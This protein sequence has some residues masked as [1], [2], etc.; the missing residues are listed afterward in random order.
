MNSQTKQQTKKFLSAI[1]N[2]PDAT[3]RFSTMFDPENLQEK[4]TSKVVN[5]VLKGKQAIKDVINRVEI[6]S[7]VIRGDDIKSETSNTTATSP[8]TSLNS[9]DGGTQTS[10][11][12]MDDNFNWHKRGRTYNNL[13]D[14]VNQIATKDTR[15]L[16]H[17]QE[18]ENWEVDSLIKVEKNIYPNKLRIIENGLTELLN[19]DFDINNSILE[20]IYDSSLQHSEINP[21]FLAFI[22][23]QM[24]SDCQREIRT[25]CSS[26]SVLTTTM[27][28]NKYN[29]NKKT[30]QFNRNLSN[31]RIWKETRSEIMRCLIVWVH[32]IISLTPVFSEWKECIRTLREGLLPTT[33][34]IHGEKLGILFKEKEITRALSPTA[35]KYFMTSIFGR[36]LM[37]PKANL[38]GRYSSAVQLTWD[39][40]GVGLTQPDRSAYQT[41]AKQITWQDK[42][43]ETR[44]NT[45]NITGYDYDSD[46]DSEEDELLK[47]P[48]HYYNEH[49][50]KAFND[51]LHSK[52]ATSKAYRFAENASA[53][54]SHKV[55]LE[56]DAEYPGD[57]SPSPTV[58]IPL[59]KKKKPIMILGNP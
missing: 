39:N 17:D 22:V 35:H 4:M 43:T 9:E 54:S 56:I 16:R 42:V 34:G 58:K 18:F 50:A 36:L 48:T 33:F 37:D 20:L 5:T 32:R 30:D 40:A 57:K 52:L 53:G 10:T 47:S 23:N 12:T 15:M 24:M 31:P 51:E 19:Y 25:I 49:N 13:G 55:T 27:E 7:T 28:M 11:L 3:Y 1:A 8:V 6:N 38:G 2:N 21:D 45:A 59:T 26:L 46:L 14:L 29:K 44:K 41:N